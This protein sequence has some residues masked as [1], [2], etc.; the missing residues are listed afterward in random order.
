MKAESGATTW[1]HRYKVSQGDLDQ[2]YGSGPRATPVIHE[3]SIYTF[4]KTGILKC[5]DKARGKPRWSRRF[6]TSGTDNPPFFTNY[7]HSASPLVYNNT[8]ILPIGGPGRGVMAFNLADGTT[9]W[10]SQDFVAGYAAPILIN[11][12]GDEQLVVFM[13][14]IVAGLDPRNGTLKWRHPHKTRYGINASMPLWGDDK[15]LF[16]SSGYETG[17]RALKLVHD[18]KETQLTERWH[19]RKVQIEFSNAIRI[20]DFVY[21]TSGYFT[22]PVAFAAINVKTGKVAW[23]KRDVVGGKASMLNVNGKLLILDEHGKLLLTSVS[24]DGVTVHA[25]HQL[26]DAVAWTVPTLVGT[27]LYVRDARDIMALDLWINTR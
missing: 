1:E 6:G 5:L 2:Q 23:R 22:G 14:E 19:Q 18:G 11:V 12:N 27:T 13:A 21:G 15:L 3:D 25:K 20:G 4:G 8:L 9:A 26:T 17:S 16:I 10:Q 24:P 7:G